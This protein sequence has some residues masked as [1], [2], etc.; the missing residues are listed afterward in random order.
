MLVKHIDIMTFIH[1]NVI[2]TIKQNP[3]KTYSYISKAT[4]YE[5]AEMIARVADENE[6]QKI[7]PQGLNDDWTNFPITYK[8]EKHSS[9]QMTAYDQNGKIM[10]N[11][12]HVGFCRCNNCKSVFEF[13]NGADASNDNQTCYECNTEFE[14]GVYYKRH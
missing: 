14:D 7:E 10:D 5:M 12:Y 8:L 4:K 11:S 9:W 13:D 6:F 3:R 2:M 1:Y